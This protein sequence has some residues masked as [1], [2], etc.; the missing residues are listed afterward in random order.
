M[1]TMLSDMS[2]YRVIQKD[3][4]RSLQRK[5]NGLLLQLKKDGSLPPQVYNRPRCSS[6]SIP[7]IYGLPKIHKSG[8]PLKPIVSF[9]TSPTYHLSKHLL[10]H[11]LYCSIF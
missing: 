5:M 10:R 4:T 6:G 1:R 7:S 9:Y 8:V 11:V 2:T 3:P